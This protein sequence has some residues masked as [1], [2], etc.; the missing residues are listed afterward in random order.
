MIKKIKQWI[1]NLFMYVVVDGKDNSVTLSKRLAKR[2]KVMTLEQVK[3]FVFYIPSIRSYGFMLNP[4]FEQETQLSE[5]MYNDKYRSIGFE[6][7]CPTVNRILYD[8]G[9]PSVICKLPVK[10]CKTADS[11]RYYQICRPNGKFTR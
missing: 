3:V 6:S 9:L 7:L 1:D 5:L 2:M 4:D 11:K 8:Y 10:E